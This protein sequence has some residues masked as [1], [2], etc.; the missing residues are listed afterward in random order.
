MISDVA[1][2]TRWEW[3]K[4]RRRWMPWVLLLPLIIIPQIWLWAEFFAYR[5]VD[6]YGNRNLGIK[7]SEAGGVFFSCVDIDEG[8]FSDL[9]VKP[10]RGAAAAGDREPSNVQRDLRG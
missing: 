3:F 8:N 9:L 1:R 2:L 6:F 7:T 10:S 5:S 4:L